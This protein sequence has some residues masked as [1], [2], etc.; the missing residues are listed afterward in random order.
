MVVFGDNK[1]L[2]IEASDQPAPDAGVLVLVVLRVGIAR[3]IQIAEAVVG[4][5]DPVILGA[6]M[7][8]RRVEDPWRDLVAPTAGSRAAEDHSDFQWQ[9]RASLM[10]TYQL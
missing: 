3:L 6:A 9:G 5:I 10:L 1:D 7:G 8:A 2:A 4:Q